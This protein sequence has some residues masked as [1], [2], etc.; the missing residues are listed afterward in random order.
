M[1]A[2]TGTF[3]APFL[4][5]CLFSVGGACCYLFLVR[6]VAPLKWAAREN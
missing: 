6:E 3:Y 2:R 5:A 4:T 1:V